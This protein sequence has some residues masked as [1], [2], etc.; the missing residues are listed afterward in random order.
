MFAVMALSGDMGCAMGPWFS[1]LISDF[2]T[3]V[4]AGNPAADQIGL[5]W[6]I[7]FGVL[8]PTV[9][10]TA[11]LVHRRLKKRAGGSRF[12]KPRGT[13]SE[14][15]SSGRKRFCISGCCFKFS[16]LPIFEIQGQSLIVCRLVQS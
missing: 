6:G 16:L 12:R 1:G 9:L 5:K 2:V 8:F 7:L 13:L 11:L 3:G 4:N 14:N 10:L 15:K